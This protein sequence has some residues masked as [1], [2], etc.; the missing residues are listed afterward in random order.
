MAKDIDE[1][2]CDVFSNSGPQAAEAPH[3]SLHNRKLT[4]LSPTRS[5]NTNNAP[6]RNVHVKNL[7]VLNLALIKL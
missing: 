4:E 7:A 3:C 2:D 1:M 5:I 6:D